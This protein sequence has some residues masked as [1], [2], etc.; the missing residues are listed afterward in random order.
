MRDSWSTAPNAARRYDRHLR[1]GA[2]LRLT[3]SAIVSTGLLAAGY[4]CARQTPTTNPTPTEVVLNSPKEAARSLMLAFQAQLHAAWNNDHRAADFYRDEIANRIAAREY[5]QARQGGRDEQERETLL[6]TLV[7]NWASIVAYYIDGVDLDHML[8]GP[9]GTP[10]SVV[11]TMPASGPQDQTTIQILTMAGP[12]QQWRVAAV[13]FVPRFVAAI[14]ASAPTARVA[15]ATLPANS[16]SAAPA[17]AAAPAP[18][19]APVGR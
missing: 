1:S 10:N 14:P 11:V 6:K 12:D 16:D 7:D 15:P 9:G 19:S 4:G 2:A 17:S 8:V 5:L 18:A 3:L 13:Q